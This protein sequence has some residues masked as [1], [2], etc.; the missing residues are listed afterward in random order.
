M[1]D[2]IDRQAAID[3]IDKYD[4][5]FP[6]YMKRFV[7]GLIDAMKADLKDEIKDLPSAHPEQRWI[8]CGE[9]LPLEQEADYWICTNKGYQCQCRWTRDRYGLGLYHE[10]G[11][12]LIDIPQYT[13][14]VAWQPLPEPYK[15]SEE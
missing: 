1:S 10:W 2:L 5:G 3:A 11:W 9:R 6:Q 15:E 8:P 7:T 13:H 14:V 12:K 4:F